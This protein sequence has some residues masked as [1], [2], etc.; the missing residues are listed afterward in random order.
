[1]VATDA[2]WREFKDFFGKDIR[3]FRTYREAEKKAKE[4][5]FVPIGR[6]SSRPKFNQIKKE[7]QDF[8]D[9]KL[10]GEMLKDYRKQVMD[11]GE[12]RS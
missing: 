7:R 3:K 8:E 11:L 12:I 1:M 4:L 9:V 5:G 6:G 2:N 10:Q